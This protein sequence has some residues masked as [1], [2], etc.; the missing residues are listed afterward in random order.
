MI[1]WKDIPYIIFLRLKVKIKIRIK[2][3]HLIFVLARNELKNL[4]LEKLRLALNYIYCPGFALEACTTQSKAVGLPRFFFLFSSI[5]SLSFIPFFLEVGYFFLFFSCCFFFLIFL[6][7]LM[8]LLKITR[9]CS[10]RFG[11]LLD[12][13]PCTPLICILRLCGGRKTNSRLNIYMNNLSDAA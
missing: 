9:K 13:F 1:I 5:S 10:K 3:I 12:W 7:T 11:P 2:G 6:L 4:W 8:I